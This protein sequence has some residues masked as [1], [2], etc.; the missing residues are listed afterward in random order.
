MKIEFDKEYQLKHI[1]APLT[2]NKRH[3]KKSISERIYRLCG[4]NLIKPPLKVNLILFQDYLE[5]ILEYQI[6]N[7]ISVI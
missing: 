6:L 5:I 3:P 7:M 2:N 4:K 1:Y